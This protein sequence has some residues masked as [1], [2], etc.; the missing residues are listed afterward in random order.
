I[1]HNLPGVWRLAERANGVLFRLIYEDR[2]KE[3]IPNVL[4]ASSPGDYTYRL[5]EL[6]ELHS[7]E[8]FL[9]KQPSER[10]EYFKPH[11]FSFGSLLEAYN[12]PAFFMFG[13]FNGEDIIGYFFLRC[14]L[15]RKS[16]VGRIISQNYEGKGIGRE[17]NRIMY[18]TGWNAGFRVLSTISKNNN[19]VMRSHAGNPFI[20]ILKELKNNYVLV[21]FLPRAHQ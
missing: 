13:V 16:F 3:I 18:N 12:N 2:F 14:F 21:E 19:L 15:N 1:K 11:G 9:I 10:V 5:L 4:N 20:V 6:N 17:M 8:T 7:L